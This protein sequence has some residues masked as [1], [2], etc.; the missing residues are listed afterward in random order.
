MGLGTKLGVTLAGA[1]ALTAA[2]A[3]GWRVANELLTPTSPEATR[4]DPSSA[5]VPWSEVTYHSSAGPMPAWRFDPPSANGT[6]VVFVHGRDGHRDQVLP[7]LSTFADHGLTTLAIAYR[8]DRD[9]PPDP[10]GLCHLGH[11]EWQDVEAA[12]VH[13]LAHG[14]NDVVLAGHSMGG[15]AIGAF[16]RTSAHADRVRGAILDAPVLHWPPAIWNG[17]VREGVPRAVLPVLVPAALTTMW[18][19]AGIDWDALDHVGNAADFATPMLI[20][21]GQDDERVPCGTSAAFAGAR[22]DLVTYLPIPDAGHGQVWDADPVAVR[23][24][25]TAFLSALPER[26]T[27]RV[28]NR[29][30][31]ILRRGWRKGRRRMWPGP[32]SR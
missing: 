7:W 13:A 21:H 11:T 28:T 3:G 9:A 2:A 10:D 24:A 18:A 15:A 16:L 25:T 1:G 8:N 22:P 14:A 32:V 12:V 17:L 6:W 27:D 20:L 5:G 19:R 23:T 4:A 26:R 29:A 30:K 31:R